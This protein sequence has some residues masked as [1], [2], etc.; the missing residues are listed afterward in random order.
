MNP[1]ISKLTVLDIVPFG[2]GPKHEFFALRLTPPK[3]EGSDPGQFVM[4]RP[5]PARSEALC[6]RPFSICKLTGGHLIVFFQVRG[7][8]TAEMAYLRAGDSV[9]VTGPLGNS[10]PVRADRPTLIL[11]GGIGIAPFVEYVDKHPR[12]ATLSVEFAHRYPLECYPFEGIAEKCATRSHPENSGQDRAA[13]ITLMGKRIREFTPAGLVLACGPTPFLR[14]VR[15]M[16]T[17]CGV[18]A[19]LCLETRMACGIGACLGCAVKAHL[20]A[21]GGAPPLLR[22]GPAASPDDGT[23]VRTC[24]CGP[25]FRADQVIF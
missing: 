14:L 19:H 21:D 2:S 22:A 12:P 25:N 6:P 13:F 10:L 20:P 8:V 17:A 11:A 7:R 5:L 1:I 23:F 4:L 15:D 18:E 9:Q 3:W 16:S 24:A